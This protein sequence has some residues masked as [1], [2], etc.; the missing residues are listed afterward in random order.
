MINGCPSFPC[1]AIRRLGS[2]AQLRER[3]IGIA[4][5]QGETL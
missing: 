4:A 2:P 5:N 3:E 1:S